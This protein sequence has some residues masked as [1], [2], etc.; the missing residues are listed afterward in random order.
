VKQI[1]ALFL[2]LSLGVAHAAP[3]AT[4][5]DI[6][7]LVF[8]T[9]LPELEGGEIWTKTNGGNA[10]PDVTGAVMMDEALPSDSALT[11][12]AAALQRDGTYRLLT[13]QRWRQSAEEKSAA[14]PVRLRTADGLLDGTVRFY[15][16]RFLHVDVDVALQDRSTPGGELIYR[17]S[18]HRRVKTQD[19]NYFDHPK[20]GVLLRVTAV[21]KE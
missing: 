10:L 6:E 15:L 5:Y 13:H 2:C 14:K 4:A 3:V 8:E 7:V 11:T 1:L 20:L 18:E 19:T 21:G 12:A 16:S 9:R 17:L